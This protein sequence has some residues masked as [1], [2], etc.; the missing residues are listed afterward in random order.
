MLGSFVCQ[1]FSM[2]TTSKVTGLEKTLFTLTDFF[3]RLS[4]LC[5]PW[6]PLAKKKRHSRGRQTM[7]LVLIKDSDKDKE[8]YS[9]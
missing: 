4:R 1:T 8:I 3:Q 9:M 2:V 6:Q 7:I 5:T